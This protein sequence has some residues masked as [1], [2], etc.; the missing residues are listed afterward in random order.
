[1]AYTDTDC[2]RA[3]RDFPSLARTVNGRPIAY[4]D[5]PAG[6]Q[7]PEPVIDAISGYYRTSNANQH[8][9]FV[10]SR[11]T[12]RLLEETRQAVAAFL[13]AA[14]GREIS[15]GQN[16]TTLTF[17]LSHALVREMKPGDE[18]VIT[19][20]DHEANRG[21]WLMLRERGVEIREVALRPDGT[22][23]PEDF[24]RQMTERTRLVA[25]GAA[26]NALGTV[27][28]LALARR[29]ATEAGAWLLVDAVHHA[30][31]FPVDVQAIDCDFLLCSAYKFYGP[32]VGLLYAKPGLLDRLRT[33][34]LRT[35]EDAAPY[36]I[37]TGTLNH[38]AIAGVKAA[39][40][41]IA[42]WGRGETLRERIVTAMEDIAF[43]EHGIAAHYHETVRQIPGVRV[44]GTDFSSPH[45]APTVSITV[46]GV[47]AQEVARRLGE[48][49]LQVWDG[50]FYAIR[51]IEVLGLADR[52]GIVRTGVCMYNTRE[53]IERLVEAVAALAP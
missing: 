29:L 11:E 14:S 37:E 39:I 38:A 10:T 53:E 44:W 47:P 45:R 6:T 42:T 4:L 21:P 27:N 22:L 46:D 41:Y 12:D 35:Q 23:D 2:Q 25:L 34:K 16:M 3:R 28:D 32:H 19:Q 26:S 24:A 43:Y 31:H 8:G 13:G 40:E 52:G 1:M 36:R 30:A 51:A 33:D 18:V 15:F 9:E 17:A 48:A 50:H 5:G 7:V 49:G 20:L